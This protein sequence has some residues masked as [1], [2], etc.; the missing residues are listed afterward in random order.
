M[1]RNSLFLGLL[2]S[3]LLL[4]PPAFAT[5]LSYLGE[6][7]F[8]WTS[9]SISGIPI[10]LTGLGLEQ[11]HGATAQPRPNT[12]NPGSGGTFFDWSD[13]TFTQTLPQAATSV[14]SADASR[15]FASVSMFGG[16]A[17]GISEVGRGAHFTAMQAGD[18]SISIRYTLSHAGVPALQSDLLSNATASLSI[19]AQFSSTTRSE[20]TL[21][22]ALGNGIQTGTL[23]VTR[24]LREGENGSWFVFGQVAAT[25]T[26]PEPDMLWPTLLGMITIAVY[27]ERRRRQQPVT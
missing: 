8:D 2:L 1:R 14:S 17:I 3:L 20:R 7:S 12:G 9:L 19:G 21:S 16:P 6:A 24:S 25:S 5:S 15:L 11:Q 26:V 22:S 27:V 13:R 4:G 18:L 10:T 23:S